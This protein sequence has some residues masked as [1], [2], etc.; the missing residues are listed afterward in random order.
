MV[1]QRLCKV[2]TSPEKQQVNKLHTLW[3]Q[4]KGDFRI[5]HTG[6]FPKLLA[7]DPPHILDRCRDIVPQ[8]NPRDIPKN[9][10][11]QVEYLQ[12]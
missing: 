8:E 2:I 11:V 4:Q 6:L 9:K 7:N 12:M 5:R 1:L 3:K 10:T